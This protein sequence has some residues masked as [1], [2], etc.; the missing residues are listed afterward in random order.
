MNSNQAL[1]PLLALCILAFSSCRTA[2]KIDMDSSTRI[3]FDKYMIQGQNLYSS[4]C[5]NCH[6]KDGSGLRKL[7]PPLTDQQFLKNQRGQLPCHLKF[8]LEGEIELNSIVFNQP[9]PA[10]GD[11]TPLEIAEILTYITNSWGNAQGIYG[12]GEVQSAL[13]ECNP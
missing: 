11:I 3:K 10:H 9:M 8:G 7:I 5:Q 13:L 2:P 12:V 1:W 4:H 6:Q